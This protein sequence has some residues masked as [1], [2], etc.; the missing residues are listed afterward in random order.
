M[1]KKLDFVVDR[2]KVFIETRGIN[3]MDD[4]IG[5]KN[6]LLSIII[7]SFEVNRFFGDKE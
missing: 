4:L 3:S 2:V 1:E 7:D 5:K 6:D